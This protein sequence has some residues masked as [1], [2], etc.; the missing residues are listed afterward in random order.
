MTDD[1]ELFELAARLEK[2]VAL[3]DNGRITEPLDN[4]EDAVKAVE[5]AF[6]E[7]WQGYHAN[8]YYEGFQRPPPGAHFRIRGQYTY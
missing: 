1:N 5:P 2:V 4:I 6:S 8:V 7:S 3:L